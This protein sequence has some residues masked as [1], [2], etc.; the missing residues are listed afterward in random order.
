MKEYRGDNQYMLGN[1]CNSNVYQDKTHRV[2]PVLSELFWHDVHG[3][4]LRFSVALARRDNCDV[5]E[6]FA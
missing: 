4:A 2:D 5:F 1:P 3:V 6:L